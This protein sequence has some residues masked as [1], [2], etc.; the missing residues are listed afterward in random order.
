[1]DRRMA[2][3]LDNYITG[4]YGQDQFRD[5]IPEELYHE[6][7]DGEGCTECNNT[8]FDPVKMKAHEEQMKRENEA[9]AKAYEESKDVE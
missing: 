3:E 7:C 1:M 6:A 5:D 4:H 9:M 8:G 2:Q